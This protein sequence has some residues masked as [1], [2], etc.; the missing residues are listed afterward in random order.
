M[1][2]RRSLIG[3][4]GAIAAVWLAQ[5]GSAVEPALVDA[6][7]RLTVVDASRDACSLPAPG[8]PDARRDAFFRGRNLFRQV[9]I[10]APSPDQAVDGLGPV[11]N[12][13]SCIACHARNGRGFAPDG[14]AEEMRAMLVRLSLPGSG[15]HGAPIPVPAYGDQLNDGAIPGGP[16]EGRAA[17]TYSYRLVSLSGGETVQLRRPE[18]GFRD[19]AFG[20]LD[21][22]VL[23]SARIGP[24]VFGLGLLNAVR[25]ETLMRLAARP[26]GHAGRLNQVW[27]DA[28]RQRV[29]G[30]FGAKANQPSVR[31]QVASAFLGDLGITSALYPHENCAPAQSAC[32]SAPDGGSP[33]LSETQ[34]DDLVTYLE[35]LAV[36]ARRDRARSE[37]R[38]GER[39]FATFGCAGCHVSQLMT[40]VPDAAS[41]LHD[42]AIQAWTDLL[43]HDLGAGL[44]DGRPAFAASGNEWRTAPLWGIGL[45]EHVGGRVGYLHD[46]RARTLLEAILW[47]GGEADGARDAVAAAARAERSALLAFLKSL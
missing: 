7:G 35:W 32:R 1:K 12:R 33:E 6:G 24:A 28:A 9:W 2:L 34:L 10:A 45:A 44:A 39:L 15:P 18:I 23:V 36:P 4:A 37:V 14:P 47:H 5:A 46:G 16:R 13:Q 26:G 43:L 31:Q 42:Q 40:A 30:R 29:P 41:D 11:F 3:T 22:D 27:D 19:L 25:D 17:V 20:P 21:A 8:L 38:Q